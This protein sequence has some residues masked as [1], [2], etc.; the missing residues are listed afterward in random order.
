MESKCNQYIT[1]KQAFEAVANLLVQIAETWNKCTSN[2]DK[3][4]Y[5]SNCGAKMDEKEDN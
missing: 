1:K 2:D 4:K 3:K 5:C